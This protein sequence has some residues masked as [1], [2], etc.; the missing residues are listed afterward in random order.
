[1]PLRDSENACYLKRV[2]KGSK[3]N[4]SLVCFVILYT[5]RPPA[6]QKWPHICSIFHCIKFRKQII[7]GSF[8]TC[9]FLKDQFFYKK[10]NSPALNFI[11][12][13]KFQKML[14]Y[15]V[16]WIG[17]PFFSSLQSEYFFLLFTVVYR[18]PRF[19]YQ[20]AVITIH[21]S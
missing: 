18:F 8:S 11:Y 17:I 4:L 7:K 10:N 3:S 2:L 19:R 12:V 16:H 5:I 13:F 21:L 6:F 15:S 1:M 20:L 9:F 14:K